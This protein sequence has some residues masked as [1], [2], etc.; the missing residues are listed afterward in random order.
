[1][2]II[3]IDGLPIMDTDLRMC[4]PTRVVSP[5]VTST[6]GFLRANI[7]RIPKVYIL[8]ICCQEKPNFTARA[9]KAYSLLSILLL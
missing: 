1:M 5:A 4:I 3:I 9:V 8:I 6:A 7:A 2:E